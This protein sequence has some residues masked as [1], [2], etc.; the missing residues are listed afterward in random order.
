MPV[1]FD[2]PRPIDELHDLLRSGE[3]LTAAG[4]LQ[5]LDG[6]TSKRHVRR[7]LRRLREEHQLPIQ[8]ERRGREKAFYL[9]S[10]ELVLEDA[11]LDLTERQAL[12]LAVAAESGRAVLKPTP[13]AKPLAQAFDLLLDLLSASAHTYD[14]DRIR[15][16]WHFNTAP[17]AST[18]DHDVFDDLVRALNER[19][20]VHMTYEP[21][22]SS[23]A[24]RDRS[25]T[26]LVMAAPGSSWRCIAYCH[27]REAPRDFTLSRI[28][29][30]EVGDPHTG[31]DPVEDF[32]PELYFRER[33]GDLSGEPNVVR[34]LVK[35]DN[36]HL[37]REKSF[38]PT[39][40]IEEE[41]DGGA[42]VV[43]FEVSGVES[44]TSWIR[45]WGAGLEVLDP[46]ELREQLV[47]DAQAVL[48]QYGDD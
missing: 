5:E 3:V 10:E 45:S 8:D 28:E 22:S 47:A 20:R 44:I 17:A 40:V 19:R 15:E 34:L 7:L 41:R 24:P 25:V 48:S 14:L 4:A 13:L 9:P 46:P 16:Q 31:D 27:Y 30:L 39:Q 18:F 38:H 23:D 11:A 37:F 42:L 21:A 2:A 32:D 29:K 12:A 1:S 35:A 33:F 6:V 43:S 36:A 26:P